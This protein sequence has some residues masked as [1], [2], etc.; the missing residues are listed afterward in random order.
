MDNRGVSAGIIG[1]NTAIAGLASIAA[2]PIVIPLARRFGTANVMV[3]CTIVSAVTFAGFY[4]FQSLWVWFVLRT[5]EHAALAILF[6]LSEFWISTAADPKKRG[7][8]LGVYGTVLSVG[9]A[10]GPAIL[11]YIGTAGPAPFIIGS[12]IIA[13]AIVPVF[14]AYGT[15]PV[16]A[17]SPIRSV[18]RY[19]WLVPAATGAV[20]VFGCFEQAMLGLFPVYGARTGHGETAIAVLLVMLA[21]G[22]IVAE[23]PIGILSDKVRDR[24]SVLAGCALVCVAGTVALPAFATQPIMVA[25]YLVVCGGAAGGMY[26]AGLA[27]LGARL[28][29]GELAQANAAFVMAYSI[30]M[31]VGPYAIGIATEYHDPHG[32]AWSLALIV[33]IYLMVL[34]WRM[35]NGTDSA[36]QQPS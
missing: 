29:S 10:A 14:A 12:S 23:V 26:T 33:M 18:F 30:G 2:V 24:R 8:V 16:I 5:I 22:N 27:H 35:R 20:F 19:L 9:F 3:G 31:M 15:Q 4:F 6:V 7:L 13:V 11:A 28:S 32:F 17:S 1:A 21:L 25:I 34:M 36:G